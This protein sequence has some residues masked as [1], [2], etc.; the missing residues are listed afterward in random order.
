MAGTCIWLDKIL[1]G[2]K[3]DFESYGRCEREV[4]APELRAAGFRNLGPWYDGERDSF[5]PLT[6]CIDTDRGTVVYG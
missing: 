1:P 3:V 4:I 5:G 2:V 6:R